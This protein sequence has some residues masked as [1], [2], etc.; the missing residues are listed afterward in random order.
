M[1]LDIRSIRFAADHVA[2]GFTLHLQNQGMLPA[3]GLISALITRI[4]AIAPYA[5]FAY[6]P[7]GFVIP[8][9]A[10]WMARRAGR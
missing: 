2:V 1:A 9:Y 5:G 6:A 4:S 7:L 8:L 10:M 3:T